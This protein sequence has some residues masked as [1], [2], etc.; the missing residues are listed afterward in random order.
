MTVGLENL[1]PVKLKDAKG[2]RH[3]LTNGRFVAVAKGV[4]NDGEPLYAVQ[5]G[6]DDASNIGMALSAEAMDTIFGMYLAL[7]GELYESQAER[8]AEPTE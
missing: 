1:K 5:A 7:N 3:T 2:F 4:G 6:I 8:L